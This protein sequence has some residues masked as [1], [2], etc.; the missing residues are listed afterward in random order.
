MHCYQR[1]VLL[2]ELDWNDSFDRMKI[3][4]SHR[5][6]L[7]QMLYSRYINFVTFATLKHF[8][9]D[10]MHQFN[11]KALHAPQKWND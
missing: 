1:F 5:L 7:V 6:D 8:K 3:Q 9:Q 10:C 11:L 2:N 4:A